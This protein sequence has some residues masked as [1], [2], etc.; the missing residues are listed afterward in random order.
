SVWSGYQGKAGPFQF[1][2]G[3]RLELGA[4]MTGGS[5]SN[6]FQPRLS[7]SYLWLANWRFKASFGRVTQR[8]L[9]IANED[10]VVSVFEGWISV[11]ENLPPEQADHYIVGISGSLSENLSVNLEGYYKYYRSLIVYNRTKI[12]PAD[13]DYIQGTGQSHGGEMTVRSKVAFVDL[14]ASYA[15]SWAT[16]DNKGFEYYPR[17]DRRHHLNLLAVAHLFRGLDFTAR[18]EYGSGFPYS[19]TIGYYDALL[20]DDALPGPFEQETG[21]PFYQLGDKNAARLPSYHRLD[22][23]MAYN[24]FPAGFDVTIGVDVLNVY[25]NDNIF[26]VDRQTGQRVNMI[27]FYPSATVTVRF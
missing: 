10:E 26:Y 18:W 2:A 20:L 12:E 11:P 24:F 7:V 4:L 25:D 3:F 1:D 22:L 5:F 13:P 23:G 14:Y 27:A 16:I 9:T 19:Q 21:T 15:L 6:E 17:Y 8:M